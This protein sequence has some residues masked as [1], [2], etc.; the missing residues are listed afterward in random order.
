MT[1]HAASFAHDHAAAPSVDP[2]E[3]EKFSRI[4]AE[5]W[6]PTGKFRPLHKFNPARV[7]YIRDAILAHFALDADAAPPLAGLSLLDVGCGGGLVCEPMARL[8]AA[9]TGIDAAARNIAVARLHAEQQDLNIRYLCTSAEALAAEAAGGFDVVLNLE[10]VEHVA[11][12]AGFLAT[13]AR[14]LKPGGLMIVATLNR[15]AKALLLAKI[16]AEYVLRWLPPGTHDPRKF[17]RPDEL[18][19]HLRA[20]GMNVTA[21]AGFSYAPLQDRWSITSDLSVNYMLTATAS[22]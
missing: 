4:A 7:K 6:D 2:K 17:L 20:A 15:T 8:G 21:S 16:G 22:A 10:V 9:V 5:W 18:T 14:L 3:I 11:D 19:A 12:P 13:S 1:D